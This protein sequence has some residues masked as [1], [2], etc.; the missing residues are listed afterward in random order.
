MHWRND[1]PC[2]SQNQQQYTMIDFVRL[3]AFHDY[4]S[5]GTLKPKGFQRQGYMNT[6]QSYGHVNET[7]KKEW[8]NTLNVYFA[9][10]N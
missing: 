2:V 8:T 3:L 6:Q 1:Q 10:G 7:D 4:S 9:R 5:S